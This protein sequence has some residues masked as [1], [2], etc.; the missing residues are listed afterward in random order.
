MLLGGETGIRPLVAKQCDFLIS[1]PMMGRIES[2]NASVAAAVV[3]YE[4]WRRLGV[5]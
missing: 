2:L 1:I 5:S 4:L 3:L